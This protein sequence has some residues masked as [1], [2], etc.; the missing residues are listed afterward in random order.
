MQCLADAPPLKVLCKIGN[1]SVDV[2]RGCR[3]Q[4]V[5]A[6]VHVSFTQYAC[7]VHVNVDQTTQRSVL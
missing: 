4:Q 6:H 2:H 3:H 1:T 5:W 7:A